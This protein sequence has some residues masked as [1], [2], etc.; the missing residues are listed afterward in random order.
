MQGVWVQSLI[1][2]TKIR[3]ASGQ[4]SLSAVTTESVHHNEDPVYH[5][6][7]LTVKNKYLKKIEIPK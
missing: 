5:N 2:G 7:D 3:H 1:R 6:K 4:L